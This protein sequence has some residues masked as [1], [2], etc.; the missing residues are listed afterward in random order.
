MIQELTFQR[1]NK[2]RRM[3]LE[4]RPSW[5]TFLCI[6]SILE[7]YLSTSMLLDTRFLEGN[8]QKWG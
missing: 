3:R 6:A 8:I 5:R 1:I 7:H 2:I 4:M